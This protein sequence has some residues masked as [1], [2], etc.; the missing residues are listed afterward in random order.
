MPKIYRTLSAAD[1]VHGQ[2][3]VSSPYDEPRRTIQTGVVRLDVSLFDCTVLDDQCITLGAVAAKDRGTV[4]GQIQLLC[5]R[6][7]RI[8]QESNLHV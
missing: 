8:S 2:R 7:A 1:T 5:E 4:E 6:Y 3:I